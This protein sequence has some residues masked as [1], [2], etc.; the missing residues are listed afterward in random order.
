MTATTTRKHRVIRPVRWY[1]ELCERHSKV[2]QAKHAADQ[3]LIDAAI[4]D[5]GKPRQ[6]KHVAHQTLL[7][8]IVLAVII[9]NTVVLAWDFL[10]EGHEEFI[11]IID[12]AIL[13]FFVVEI[14]LR[15][16]AAGRQFWRNG[17]LVFD[18][19][20]IALALLPLGANAFALRVL[21]GARLAHFG[22]HLPHLRHLTALRW[23]GVLARRVKS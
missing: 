5:K 10:D 17:W 8:R 2:R 6:A 14:A 19:I 9:V 4:I 1:G 3:A 23:V 16:K 18:I 22:R 13:L 15:I 7:D 21:R 20:V 11:E 12:V